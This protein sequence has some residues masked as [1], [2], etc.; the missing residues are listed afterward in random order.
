MSEGEKQF[1]ASDFKLQRLREQG[2]FPSSKDVTT[3]ALVLWL[4]EALVRLSV[5]LPG[6]FIPARFEPAW[7]GSFALILLMAALLVG[8]AGRWERSLGGWWPQGV[9]DG[10]RCHAASVR[11]EAGPGSDARA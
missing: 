8:Y 6:A 10:R 5:R 2:V 7:L 4:I 1:P 11:K 3:A 9:N